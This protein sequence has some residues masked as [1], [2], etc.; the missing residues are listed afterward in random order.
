MS[1]THVTIE[2]APL[3]T[4]E[5]NVVF[6]MQKLSVHTAESPRNAYHPV[7]IWHSSSNVDVTILT[8]AKGIYTMVVWAIIGCG[9]QPPWDV[10]SDD[11]MTTHD[12]V[13]YGCRS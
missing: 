2:N 3:V 12:Y 8:M 7:F 1:R 10:D 13:R 4:D 6:H 11:L 9:V 5:I